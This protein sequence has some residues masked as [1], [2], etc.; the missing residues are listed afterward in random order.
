MTTG[1]FL[2]NRY[3]II[4]FIGSGAFGTTYLAV[5]TRRPGNP[6]C[7][8]KQLLP[9][10]KI[11][12]NL[13]TAQ[14]RFTREAQ[15]LEKLGKHSHIPQLFAY[16]QENQQFYLVEE[17]IPGYPLSSEFTL[18]CKW[19]EEKTITLIIELLEILSFIHSHGVIHRD[20]KPANI[21][22]RQSDG[23]LVLIDFGAV[24]KIHTG[25]SSSE[26]RSMATGTPA[27]MPLEQFQGH[28]KP[29]SDIYAVGMIAIQALTGVH[30]REL[31]V[32]KNMAHVHS[33][34]IYWQ[35]VVKASPQLIK[36]ID[37]MI[38]DDH[39]LRYQSTTEVLED[40]NKIPSNTLPNQK[41]INYVHAN[42]TADSTVQETNQ[43]ISES[44]LDYIQKNCRSR[45]LSGIENFFYKMS[46]GIQSYQSVSGK[47]FLIS[48]AMLVVI[49]SWALWK[50]QTQFKAKQFYNQAVEK[51]QAG[52]HRAALTDLARSIQLMPNYELAYYSRGRIR[53]QLGDYSGSIADYSRAIK[54]NPEDAGAYANR[55]VSYRHLSNFSA[56]I[57][58]CSQ[59]IS[60]NPNYA[61]AYANRCLASIGVGDAIK[62]KP[63]CNR[64]IELDPNRDDAYYGRGLTDSALGD[65]NSAIT[66]FSQAI[67]RNPDFAAAYYYRGLARV[68]LN[69][70]KTA[71]S[72]LQKAAELCN[73]SAI[74]CNIDPNT[75]L[76]KLSSSKHRLKQ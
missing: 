38:V 74:G 75:E 18:G 31:P 43:R 19:S 25:D 14:H 30:P 50:T 23:Q 17:Y 61:D 46:A 45:Y 16:F 20:I 52:E 33:G 36:I 4:Q 3:R 65:L 26:T 60:L 12:K 32:I 39:H 70:Q 71:I 73:A 57:A 47:V 58:D 69:H 64:A 9:N 63:D 13:K 2:V 21:I 62:A 1:Q 27:Y 42:F 59:A 41:P 8:V 24:K 35:R 51:S 44:R 49:A 6:T 15:T 5:D 7:L 48:L 68:E 40:I 10:P 56:A 11:G 37:K 55:C 53:F 28:P 29:N 54:L 34:Y 76:Q 67:A 66:S 72:D 22:R